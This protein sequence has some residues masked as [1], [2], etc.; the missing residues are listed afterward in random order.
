M[1]T[2]VEAAIGKIQELQ[3]AFASNLSV[4]INELN[5]S[6]LQLDK[7]LLPT[8]TKNAALLKVIYELSHKLAGSAGTF[9]FTEVYNAAKNLEHFCISL[10]SPDSN[11]DIPNNW[12]QQLIDLQKEIK[13][14]SNDKN[15]FLSA[16]PPTTEAHL[17][18]IYFPSHTSKIILV[19]DDELLAALTQEQAKH[20]GFYIDCIH[21]PEELSKFLES[22]SPEVILMDIVFPNYDFTGIE[23]V[24]QLKDQNKIHCPVIFLS[25]RTDFSAR[26]DAVR[27]GGNGYIT[28]PVN[29]LELVE[30]LDK[31]AYKNIKAA[32]KALVIDDDSMSA[33]FHTEIL[34]S[35]NF[36]CQ[37][38]N[39]PLLAIETLISFKPDI[40]LLDIHM[41]DC[42]G[43]EVAE[44]IRQDTRFTHIPILFLSADNSEECEI[45]ALKAGGSCFINKNVDKNT[46]ITNVLTQSQ[47]SRELHSVI[48]R[49]RKD[50][51][52][53]QAISHSTSDAIITLNKDGLIILWNE[54][55]ENIFGYQSIEVIGQSIE[56]IIP[57]QYREQHRKGF[58]NL[59][60]QKSPPEHN[61]IESQ[62]LHKDGSL[63]SIELSYSE[64]LSGDERFFTS[65]I[66]DTT[67]RK[68]VE[69]QLKNQ[70]E[71]LKAVVT[72][73]AEGIITINAKGTIEMA[74]PKAYQIFA[75]D[76]NELEGKNVSILMPKAMRSMHDQYL[77]DSTV[78][79]PKIIDKARELLGVR[80]N[81]SS[82]PMELNISPMS[83]N[84][85]KKFV[86]ILHDITERQN[87]LEALTNAKFAAE[88][89]NKAKSSFLSSM[90]HELRTPLNA[91]LGFSQLLQADN[92]APLNSDQQDSIEHIYNSGQHL[93]N[94]ID[95]VLDLA[96][97]ESK[98]V[99]INLTE[100][101][102][103]KL[104][105]QSL[106][107][108]A[109]QLSK[110]NISLK[111]QLPEQQDIF[112]QADALR[113]TQVIANFLSN[114]IKYNRKQ[115]CISV[116]LSQEN[117][118]VR[119]F[120]KDTGPGIP[121]KMMKDL[122]VPFN[123]L[124]AEQS[125]I[126]GTGIGLTITK[127]LVEMMGGEIGVDNIPGEGCTFWVELEQ[128][129]T[130]EKKSSSTAVIQESSVQKHVN[131]NV[132]YI[133]D[134]EINRLLIKK[135]IN[136]KTDFQ[137]HEAATGQTGIQ[138]ALELKPQIIL[139]DINL[140][141]ID[142]YQIYQ[143]LQQH[144]ALRQT[145]IIII[146]ANAMPED[147]EKSRS[148]D[149]FDYITKPIEQKKL[150]SSIN[151]ALAEL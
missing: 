107:S 57:E 137:Y 151:K 9:Q 104:L 69:Y 113:L 138:A 8:T 124:G 92:D 122:F 128:T 91:V 135:I 110:A 27:S 136:A 100:V 134:N 74:N 86:G 87:T 47:R 120:V 3:Q 71:N 76:G 131:A 132:L 144:D 119:L 43:Y 15:Q 141:D 22:H 70:Q 126:E 75:Y 56:L 28:K 55:A 52:R 67:Q 83:I 148:G 26:L 109:P 140:P 145:K 1:K 21:N 44:V 97:I 129:T 35:I 89:A 111:Q 31:H 149:F 6:L 10:L 58:Y 143:Q 108:I 101:N 63:I 12:H 94:L 146:S 93:L 125:D 34:Q 53:F 117:N 62:A 139:L 49:L 114:A 66:R 106:N 98:Q 123:R 80:K 118:K 142:G 24:K 96:K 99:S 121:E 68:A 95:E 102:L 78:H 60:S 45:A 2:K 30:I 13:Q 38:I 150:L 64:W 33:A 61:S 127:M 42:S 73:S 103:I 147:I 59:V 46:F 4:R 130:S 18:D 90:S 116:Y 32:P 37:L 39:N 48:N 81:G 84:G 11:I 54:G 88:E 133:E 36:E 17:T 23:L 72:N 85:E 115:G 5:Q 41:P 25:N 51:L 65:I 16:H 77:K 40:V 20:F 112:V 79:I 82:F 105:E 14:G 7:Q 50:E 19:D 29:I